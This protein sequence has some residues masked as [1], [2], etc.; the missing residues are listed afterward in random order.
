MPFGFLFDFQAASE[1]GLQ[2]GNADFE[3]SPHL[4]L[5]IVRGGAADG[6]RVN[7]TELAGA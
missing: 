6:V 7:V 3:R 1:G 5:G 4:T 2:E